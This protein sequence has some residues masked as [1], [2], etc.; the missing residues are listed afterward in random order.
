MFGAAVPPLGGRRSSAI[1]AF[2]GRSGEWPMR[3]QD[4]TAAPGET[5]RPRGG[6]APW[7]GSRHAVSE[8]APYVPEPATRPLPPEAVQEPPARPARGRSR[9]PF[10]RGRSRAERAAANRPAPSTPQPEVPA[11]A[12]RP[13]VPAAAQRSEVP[14][15]AHR[16]EVPAAAHRP[17]VPAAVHL[18]EV[19][20]AVH[21]P[22][23]PA[24][25]HLPEV[26]LPG[27]A[28]AEAHR[29]PD[30]GAWPGG[31]PLTS[32]RSPASDD[33]PASRSPLVPEPHAIS[34]PLPEPQPITPPLPVTPAP[35]PG[36]RRGREG[37]RKQ[38]DD[39]YVDWVSGLGGE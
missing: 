31:T 4:N 39:E 32:G 18:P 13:D 16:P 23:V 17:E 34:A 1:D 29:R 38:K 8:P 22:E 35:E 21:L 26:P 25:V 20:A 27:H 30:T 2:T 19:P 12:H 28:E 11:A 36:N 37:K 24:A 14:A 3:R 33:R 10:G 7:S 9:L 15:A 5:G 6:T